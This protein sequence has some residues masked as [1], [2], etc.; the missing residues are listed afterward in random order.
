MFFSGNEVINDVP[1]SITAPYIRAVTRDIKQYIK[2]HSDRSIPV[3]Y[4]AADVREVLIDSWAYMQCSLTGDDTDDSIADIFALNSYSWCG[5]ATFEEAGYDKLVEYFN[6]TSIPVFMSEY[7]CN[8]IKPRVFDEVAGLYGE[9]M[10]SFFSGGVVYEYTQEKNDYGLV[11]LNEDGSA[12]LRTDYDNFQKQLNKLNFTELQSTKSLVP[13]IPFPKCDKKLIKSGKF[14]SNFTD[15]P[16]PPKDGTADLIKNGIKANV[17][18]N[19]AGKIIDI[20]DEDLVVKQSVENTDQTTIKDL[21]VIR[22][23]E[24]KANTPTG[25]TSGNGTATQDEGSTTSGSKPAATSEDEGAGAAV[26]ASS[27]VVVAGVMLAAFA[28]L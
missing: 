23:A 4:S 19:L 22:L 6:E 12:T 2:A 1:S 15:I 3:G 16:T 18:K 10:T 8:E 27:F 17:A 5:D 9:R 14:P 11:V 21:K 26:K 25:I 28:L 24:D 7:G 20:K 13:E